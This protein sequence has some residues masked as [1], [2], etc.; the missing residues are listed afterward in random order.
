MPEVNI[1][2]PM[3]EGFSL[4]R[5]TKLMGS[6]KSMQIVSII[7]ACYSGA[8]ILPTIRTKA[9]VAKEAAGRALAAYDRI[10]EN[11][12]RAEGRCFL[13]SSQAYEP[14]LASD[15]SY[16]LY[17][18]YLIE[19]FRGA[20][21]GLDEKG[22][23]YPA[24]VDDDGNVTPETLHKYV[25]YR[26]ANEAEQVPKIKSD[27]A[28]N[29][30]LAHHP[31]LSK[32][33]PDPNSIVKEGDEHF[34]HE[35]YDKAIECY[36]R[37]IEADPNLVDAWHKKGNAL[38]NKE[39]YDEALKS[40]DRASLIN[41]N[42][43]DS[44]YKKGVVY[45]KKNNHDQ[46][47]KCYDR[48]IQLRTNS[49]NV[50]YEKGLSL[51]Y[52]KK[53][54]EA[55]KCYDNAIEL[56]P[57]HAEAWYWKGYAYY[58]MRMDDEALRCYNRAKEI[59]PDFPDEWYGSSGEPRH[60]GGDP[61]PETSVAPRAGEPAPGQK[62]RWPIIL[63]IIGAVA[64]VGL[65]LA[66][67]GGNILSPNDSPP[68]A[69]AGT[70]KT[71]NAASLVNLDGSSSRD[72]NDNDRITSYRW[73]QTGGSPQIELSDPNSASP[74]FTAPNVTSD[75]RFTFRL[76]VTDER[77]QS[78]DDNVE[79]T[80]K[81]V[82]LVTLPIPTNEVPVA[83]NKDDVTTNQNTPAQI[84]LSASDA[85]NDPLEF[86]ISSFPSHGS[87]SGFDTST[88]GAVT[89]TP[90]QDYVGKDSFT[91]KATDN[92]GSV[93]NTATVSITV[94][95]APN[96]IPTVPADQSIIVTEEDTSIPITL[97]ANDADSSDT[98]T[99]SIVSQPSHGS[100]SG[101]APNLVYAPQQNYVGDDSFTYRVNDGKVDS[102][103]GTVTINV[104]GVNDR[105]TANAG[106]DQIVNSGDTVTL[107]GDASTDI[108]GSINSYSWQQ[109][110][111]PSVIN[112]TGTDTSSPRFV[113][114]SVSSD[115]KLEFALVVTDDTGVTSPPDSISV[116]VKAR[117]E[118]KP[119]TKPSYNPYNV[120]L[121]HEAEYVENIDR[122]NNTAW[123]VADPQTLSQIKNV[124]YYFHPTFDP[125]VITRYSAEDRFSDQF[126]AWGQFT[127]RADVFFKDGKVIP[128]T[129][130][131]S[132]Y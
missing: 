56:Y 81:P 106:I 97:G 24:S 4:T 90:N 108:D 22:L 131:I 50:W 8:A 36:N 47:I 62:F 70:D 6:S 89:Y 117:P 127:L 31:H 84:T 66:F 82:R 107:N 69:E 92:K 74:T 99:F 19:G 113:A 34:L 115:T 12:P 38:Y 100:L 77:G 75:T 33:Q 45:K 130:Y 42:H 41:P 86:T 80:V 2:N 21:A 104:R 1:R 126:I 52:L 68:I 17:T 9:M 125:D 30:I 95:P 51:S 71:V 37:A 59:S 44:W 98:L 124:T 14:S 128:V 109:T 112:L 121:T 116:N 103:I 25:Y 26:V 110:A 11:I 96:N 83:N 102:N 105:P 3:I 67:A 28:S 123:I 118:P 65:I 23:K 32:N 7:D 15:D 85:N 40:Y 39:N 57:Q 46:A 53:Y 122:Y 16:S 120:Y 78:A 35:E 64:A 87:L 79:I 63:A 5:L 129:R 29:I 111:G 54:Q 61:Q 91:F 58:K 73:E 76:T 88:T 27:M 13:L 49:R 119:E 72:P 55:I 48:A 101:I 114:P 132:F 18:K 43:F 93:S 94:M 10:L 20:K 60:E